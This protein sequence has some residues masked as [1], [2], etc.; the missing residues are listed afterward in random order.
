[1]AKGFS[2]GQSH[3]RFMPSAT[4]NITTLGSHFATGR[5]NQHPV[6]LLPHT[7]GAVGKV[8]GLRIE[9]A[10]GHSTPWLG[11]RAS[12][13]NLSNWS[14]LLRQNVRRE[15]LQIRSALVG[16]QLRRN[17]LRLLCET[18]HRHC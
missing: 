5:H 6:A 12:A 16:F 14:W 8:K 13:D 1:M 18:W 10:P 2:P 4:G 15:A 9:Q 17:R 11:G 3:I 7:L